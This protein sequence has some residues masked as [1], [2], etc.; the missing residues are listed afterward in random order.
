MEFS[1][2]LLLTAFAAGS[3]A[4]QLNAQV[5][6]TAP[7][8]A[9]NTLLGNHLGV[10]NTNEIWSNNTS[11]S[12]FFN[13]GGNAEKTCFWNTLS[14]TTGGF[15]ILTLLKSGNVGITTSTPNF[16]LQVHGITDYV[17]PNVYTKDGLLIPG[18]NYGKTSR[19]GLTNTTTG[20]NPSDGTVLQMSEN[21]FRFQNQENGNMSFM[22]GSLVF[23]MVGATSKAYFGNSTVYPGIN[24]GLLNVQSPSNENGMFIRTAGAGKY[25]LG[26]KVAADTDNALLVYGAD[27]TTRTFQVK[28]NGRVWATEIN[29]ILASTP[30]PDYV[31]ESNYKLKTLNE[32]ENHITTFGHLPNMPSATQVATDGLNIGET[33]VVLVEKIEELTLYLIEQ[34]K[35]IESLKAQVSELKSNQKKGE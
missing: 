4:L 31:F 3:F 26:L 30:F 14:N 5:T 24:Y 2:K 9:G 10:G 19:I 27:A 35:M 16:N 12:L 20:T 33:T 28:G 11:K 15:S 1:K 32:V 8:P 18:V 21:N 23:N 22:T 29:V 25:A 6:N 13:Y 34:Q 17:T 7:L